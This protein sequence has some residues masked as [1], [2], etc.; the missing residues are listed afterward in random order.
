[1]DSHAFYHPYRRQ[2][3]AALPALFGGKGLPPYR[4]SR[5]FVGRHSH[6]DEIRARD[7]GCPS[8][9]ARR[10]PAGSNLHESG[11]A[12][13]LSLLRPAYS[14][15]EPLLLSIHTSGLLYI[16]TFRPRRQRP[17]LPFA[18]DYISRQV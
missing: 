7:T 2:R 8:L 3:I 13:D 6:A 10:L 17:F 4:M 1:M 18:L 9:R 15:S 16:H 14:L 11:L 5:F 12:G